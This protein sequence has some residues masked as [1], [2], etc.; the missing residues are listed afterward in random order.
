MAPPRDP[1]ASIRGGGR[2]ASNAAASAACCGAAPT[3]AVD[4]ALSAA[5]GSETAVSK[6]PRR[7]GRI[8]D[9]FTATARLFAGS[10]AIRA[11]STMSEAGAIVM[12]AVVPSPANGF[13]AGSKFAQSGMCSSREACVRPRHH[14]LDNIV[15]LLLLGAA[16]P[17]H[18]DG[19]DLTL[20]LPDAAGVRPDIL[21][22]H[23]LQSGDPGLLTGQRR[24]PLRHGIDK[25]PLQPAVAVERA[26]QIALLVLNDG[27]LTLQLAQ[28]PLRQPLQLPLQVK[29]APDLA[30]ARGCVP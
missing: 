16:P 20:A 11:S 7:L 3:E 6:S 26:D 14:P 13:A 18:R 4:A 23:L 2:C 22:L 8:C 19:T 15:E 9:S 28:P 25:K 10:A 27:L 21:V 29:N 1:A 12:R 30:L 24:Q 5:S 17:R